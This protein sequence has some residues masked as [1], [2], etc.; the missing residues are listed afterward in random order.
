MNITT[1]YLGQILIDVSFIAIL[2]IVLFIGW[3]INRKRIMN[4]EQ[5]P[6]LLKERYYRGEISKRE[7]EDI[8]MDIK[9]RLDQLKYYLKI[10]K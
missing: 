6:L 8:K 9:E 4:I 5:L 2:A 10:Y 3:I 1:S 7:Y